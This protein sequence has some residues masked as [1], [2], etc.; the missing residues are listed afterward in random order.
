MR[1]TCGCGKLPN[2]RCSPPP[3][4]ATGLLSGY[5]RSAASSWSEFA[6]RL[7]ATDS[8]SAKKPS[9]CCGKA[10]RRYGGVPPPCWEETNEKKALKKNVEQGGKPPA[11]LDDL[12]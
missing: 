11:R 4:P 6:S 7:P 12:P 8:R 10:R 5:S 2:V 3:Q 1:C 9:S